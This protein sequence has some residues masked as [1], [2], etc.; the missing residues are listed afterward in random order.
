MATH[1]WNPRARSFLN[2]CGVDGKENGVKGQHHH[3]CER[4]HRGALGEHGAALGWYTGGRLGFLAA[5]IVGSCPLA[6]LKMSSISTLAYVWRY[7]PPQGTSNSPHWQR[8]EP[9]IPVLF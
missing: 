6:A 8:K 3:L 7:V 9:M 5:S 2:H 4:I 1:A